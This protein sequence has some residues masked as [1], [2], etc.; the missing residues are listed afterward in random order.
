MGSGLAATE[1]TLRENRSA[2]K[3]LE[4]FSLVQSSP[5]PVGQVP[6]VDESSPFPRTHR[7][8]RIAARQALDGCSHPPDAII[9]GTTTGGILTT[10]EMLKGNEQNKEHYRHHGLNTVADSIAEELNCTGPALV[11]STACSSGAVAIAMALKMLRNGQA[12]TVLAGGVDSLSRLTYFG[13][14]SLQLVD[15]TGCKPLDQNRQG[16]AVA[17]GAAMLLLTTEK[18]EN[19]SAELLGAGLSCDAY[20]AAAPNPEGQGAFMAM[21]NALA[22]AGLTPED[23]SYINL[24]GT[25]TPDNDLAESKALHRLF[26]TLPPLSSIK[27]ASGH[28]LAAAGA[29][30]AVVATIALSSG[31]MPANTGLQN[32]DPV[33]GLMPLVDPLEHPVKAVLSNSFGFGGNN[34]SLVLG[35]S[36]IFPKPVFCQRRSPGLAIHGYSCLSGAGD[37]AST[38]AKINNAASVAGVAGLETI[39]KH[40]PPRLIRRLKR[41]PRMTLSLATGAFESSPFDDRKPGAVFMGTGWGALSETHDFLTRLTDSKEQFPSPTDFVGSVHNGPASQ[42]AILFGATGPNI[43]TSGGDYSFEQA[44]FSAQLMLDDSAGPA[45]ILGADEG[46]DFFSPLLDASIN[47]GTTLA[48]GGGALCVDRDTKNA[49]CCISIP[50]YQ[51]SKAEN[52]IS[53]LVDSL[54]AP[55]KLSNYALIL[56]GIPAA[57]ARDGEK[58]LLEFMA[59]SKLSVPVIE[60]RKLIGEFASASAV[61]TALAASFLDSGII[62]GTLAGSS[63]IAIT[64]ETNKILVLGFGQY[65]TAIELIRL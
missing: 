22:D 38:I 3:P 53:A 33:L 57:M 55:G 8:A 61:A 29:I 11:V 37:I 36:G 63:D 40:L 46:H 25:G 2:I 21:Q 65:V 9:I 44:L 42:V 19:C 28:S 5:L 47:P 14:N 64:S 41:L 35:K 56:A 54:A 12:K 45:L 51:S 31:L 1:Q 20:H 34:G 6:G 13:F 16:M 18:P 58:Q 60:Y 17:E 62:P 52:V 10:E 4:L 27:G 23:I 15:Q 50:F 24:H 59:L 48:D 39:S 26:T 30:E 43:T 32:V 7:L 49:R